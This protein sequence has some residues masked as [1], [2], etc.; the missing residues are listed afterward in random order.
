MRV[1]CVCYRKDR[2]L[3]LAYGGLQRR[4]VNRD[5]KGL[6]VV[7]DVDGGLPGPA[8]ELP[9]LAYDKGG[10]DPVPLVLFDGAH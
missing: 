7:C 5:G 6:D 9:G 8:L 3:P 10:D 2:N 4:L 1:L